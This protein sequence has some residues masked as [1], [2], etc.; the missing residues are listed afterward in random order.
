[1]DKV[2]LRNTVRD[3]PQEVHVDDC[4]RHEHVEEVDENCDEDPER[5]VALVVEEVPQ[6]RRVADR[7]VAVGVRQ[8]LKINKKNVNLKLENLNASSGDSLQ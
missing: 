1:M 5:A 8:S 6:F 2:M 4:S 3:S 7:V